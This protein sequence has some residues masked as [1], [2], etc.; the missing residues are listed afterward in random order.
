M[1]IL[2]TISFL[3]LSALA[4]LL[5]R[6]F[7]PKFR[8]SWLLA[9]AGAFFAW[10][11]IF[12]WQ[13]DMPVLFTLPAWQPNILF[14]DS[15]ALLADRL[16]WAYAFSLATLGL[17]TLLT[18]SNDKNRFAMTGTLSAVAVGIIAV[19][20]KNP[21]TLVLA[22]TSIDVA[23][24]ITVVGALKKSDLREQ[25]VIA[26]T[27]R[28]LGSGFLLWAG[29]I[30]AAEGTS[31]N[32]AAVPER[33][34][35]YMLLAAGLRLGVFPPKIFFSKEIGIKHGYGT[36]LR[37]TAV[38]SG[39]ILLA[40]I[41][42]CSLQSPFIPFMLGF[43]SLTALYG[44]WR[45]S[46][47]AKI[48][49]ARQFWILTMASLSFAAALRAN[50]A[51][52][53]AWGVGLILN[54]GLLFSP[55]VK[56]KWRTRLHWLSLLAISAL[57]FTLTATGLES[58]TPVWWGF[59]LL[60]L[61][62]H[63]LLLLGYLNQTRLTRNE[64]QNKEHPFEYKMYIAGI[65]IMLFSLLLLGFW[66]WQGAFSAGTWKIS[67]LGILLFALALWAK[68]RLRPLPLQEIHWLKPPSPKN[69][70]ALASFFWSIYHALRRFNKEI[71]LILESEGGIL[72]ALLFLI[73]FASL[74]SE[75]IR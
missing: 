61:P 24:L 69:T 67:T 2:F 56:N 64:K 54:G 74:L 51:G 49:E 73:F 34:G 60:L 25:A 70:S 17:G 4:L 68:K 50:P 14:G 71:T 44:A 43:I 1:L 29:L 55:T 15:P 13:A 35:I 32:F 36:L 66:G 31:L 16:S 59:W 57:P 18:T 38:A 53:T 26:F 8:Y 65:G 41:P 52:S 7:F 46:R 10:L 19:L 63:L 28:L 58:K 42:Y 33:A 47:S 20:A 45:W 37:F 40:R 75:G 12:F 3:F 72:W 30:S 9:T 5:L 23:E 22:W 48:Q 27:V 39:L 21:L 6:I 11:S 62:A